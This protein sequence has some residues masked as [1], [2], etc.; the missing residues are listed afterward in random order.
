M[1]HY[2]EDLHS[3]FENR[4]EMRV[5]RTGVTVRKRKVYRAAAKAVWTKKTS[6]CYIVVCGMSYDMI[7]YDMM[8]RS[9]FA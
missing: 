1:V 7:R 4:R 2:Q 3:T 9:T 8:I 5:M 6:V